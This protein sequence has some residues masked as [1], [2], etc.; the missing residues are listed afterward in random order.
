MIINEFDFK[1]M[2]KYLADY[3]ISAPESDE[4]LGLKW[5]SY[6]KVLMRSIGKDLCYSGE[7]YENYI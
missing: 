6:I 1:T 2:R 7:S 5:D 4:E 3:G